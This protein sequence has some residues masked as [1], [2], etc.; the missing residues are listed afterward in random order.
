MSLHIDGIASSFLGQTFALICV[1]IFTASRE[2]RIE[3]ILRASLS[4]VSLRPNSIFIGH[5]GNILSKGYAFSLP[6]LS[7][8]LGLLSVFGLCD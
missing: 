5:R 3:E 6:T 1:I 4:K 8:Q 7:A 2:A